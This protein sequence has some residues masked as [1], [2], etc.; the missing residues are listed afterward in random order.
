M[1]FSALHLVQF[2]VWHIFCTILCGI[3]YVYDIY[4]TLCV[5]TPVA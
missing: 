1:L 2:D 3:V 5:Q 4:D